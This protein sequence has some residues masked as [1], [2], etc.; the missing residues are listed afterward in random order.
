MF[1]HLGK[2]M[3]IGTIT[4]DLTVHQVTP[5]YEPPRIMRPPV[6]NK[7]TETDP[8]EYR[9]RLNTNEL[10]KATILIDRLVSLKLYLNLFELLNSISEL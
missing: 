2:E 1:K 5:D 3:E 4:E 6:K 10:Q 9:S 7:K 8:S